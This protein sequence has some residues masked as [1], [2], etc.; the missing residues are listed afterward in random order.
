MSPRSLLPPRRPVVENGGEEIASHALQKRPGLKTIGAGAQSDQSDVQSY[1]IVSIVKR[2]SIS[3]K[4]KKRVKTGMTNNSA[5]SR[6]SRGGYG[7]KATGFARRVRRGGLPGTPARE[8][9]CGEYCSTRQL[10]FMIP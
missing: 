3:G 5:A 4:A 6:G 9:T 2:K 8:G 7:W 1:I 10:L